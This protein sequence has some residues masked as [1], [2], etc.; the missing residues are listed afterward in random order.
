MLLLLN[1]FK[2]RIICRNSIN[3]FFICKIQ[4]LTY[5]SSLEIQA[6][7]KLWK[8]RWWGEWN[9]KTC[10]PGDQR[11]TKYERQ[12]TKPNQTKASIGCIKLCLEK[13]E[14]WTSGLL[15]QS[16]CSVRWRKHLEFSLLFLIKIKDKILK[17][18]KL[19]F[20]L[21]TKLN[22][23]VC[24]E[25]LHQNV[26]RNFLVAPNCKQPTTNLDDKLWQVFISNKTPPPHKKI[27]LY[28]RYNMDES[29]KAY[30]M[31]DINIWKD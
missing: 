2:S 27:H 1:L 26:W 12:T 29:P 5:M 25:R 10:L 20:D 23:C 19:Y 8:E 14:V 4:L 24:L 31:E 15:A 13:S 17:T 30:R 6:F 9:R 22:E 7:L 11:Q 16:K 21:W 3:I 28:Y 18:Q